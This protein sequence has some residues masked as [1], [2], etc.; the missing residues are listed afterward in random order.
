MNNIQIQN[1]L[2]S[3]TVVDAAGNPYAELSFNP[4]DPGIATRGEEINE[5]LRAA[6][7]QYQ[8]ESRSS[9]DV[10]KKLR[11]MREAESTIKNC[12]DYMLGADVSGTIF[13]RISPMALCEDGSS[14][15]ENVLNAL[16]PEINLGFKERQ[17]AARNQLASKASGGRY[18][19]AQLLEQLDKVE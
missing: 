15:L 16:T 1:G 9:G 18:D 3:Y 8:T 12:I 5:T 17:A 13:K 7:A 11:A 2:V 10:L 14:Y 6:V 19:A 4:A